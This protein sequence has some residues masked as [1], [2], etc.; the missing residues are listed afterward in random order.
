MLFNTISNNSI[1]SKSINFKFKKTKDL[2]PKSITTF[3]FN[4][5]N[6]KKT[7]SQMLTMKSHPA[8]S[9]P[10]SFVHL[11]NNNISRSYLR[12]RN[13]QATDDATTQNN[14]NESFK[15]STLN[16]MLSISPSRPQSRQTRPTSRMTRPMSGI[17]DNFNFNFNSKSNNNRP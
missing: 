3:D 5:A 1:N 6:C 17:S 14:N 4:T 8:M 7:T 15:S 13:K 16:K 12:S 10:D 2:I 11:K 9:Q